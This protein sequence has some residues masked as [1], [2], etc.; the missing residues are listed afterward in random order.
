MEVLKATMLYGAQ[1]WAKATETRSYRRGLES[2]YRL[3]ALRVCCGFRTV[4]DDAALV[5]A[6]MIPIDLLALEAQEIYAQRRQTTVDSQPEARIRKHQ[7]RCRAIERWQRRWNS[8]T[9][10][11]WTHSLIPDVRKWVQRRHGQVNFHLTQL[12][13][14]HGVFRK[15]LHRF[16]HDSSPE[17]PLCAMDEDAEH[18]ILHCPRFEESRAMLRTKI[19]ET[20]SSGTLV[21][22]MLESVENWEAVCTFAE[23]TMKT[24]RSVER[25]RRTGEVP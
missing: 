7:A 24:L 1:I 23:C 22:S 14:G 20:L 17:C 13:S 10:G 12:L 11:R 2:T 5:I 18:V 3:G 21:E 9:K 6:G 8:S 4:S 15:Y 25:Q 16:G 19:G